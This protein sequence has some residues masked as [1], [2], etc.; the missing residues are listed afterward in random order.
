MSDDSLPV[1]V[2]APRRWPLAGRAARILGWLSIAIFGLVLLAWL[3]M[4]WA[5]LPHIERWRPLIEAKTSQA[6]GV[7]VRIGAIAV[8]SGRFGAVLELRDVALLDA[9]LQPALQLP[10]V[11]ATISMRSLLASI[12]YREPR[13]AQLLIDGAQIDV[14]RDAEGRLFVAGIDFGGAQRNG[15][16]DAADWFFKLHEFAIRGGT[17]RWTDERRGAPPLEL[18]SVDIVVRNTLKRHALRVDATPPAEWGERFTLRGKFTQP[19]LARPGNWRAWSGSLYVDLPHVDVSALAQD[20]DVPFELD[21]GAGAARA[22]IDVKDGVP[23]G[24]TADLAL[25]AVSLR[26]GEKLEPLDAQQLQGRFIGTRAPGAASAALRG[27]TLVTGDGVQWSPGDLDMRWTLAAD[28]TLTGGTLRAER[29]DL[30][31]LARTAQRIPLGAPLR[32]WL[33]L[34]DPKGSATDV[35]ASWEGPI[36]TPKRY[37]VSAALEGFSLAAGDATAGVAR[38]GLRNASLKFAAT[39]KGGQASIGIKDGAIE[40]PGVFE[41]P[42]LPFAELDGQ[43]AWRIDARPGQAPAI[44]VKLTHGR[45]ANADA[46]GE[47][48]ATWSSDAPGGESAGARGALELDATLTNADATRVA[49]YL[50]LAMPEA[51]R[52]YVQR[53]V[54]GGK[55]PSLSFR[56]RGPLADFP[57]H[58]RRTGEFR[59]AIKTEDLTFA[60]APDDADTASPWPPLTRATGEIVI[61]R[62]A[63]SFE[64]TSGQLLGLAI[65]GLKGGIADLFGHR[66]LTLQAQARGPLADMLQIVNTT[67]TGDRLDGAL[68]EMTASGDGT[69]Q[70]ALELPLQNPAGAVASGSLKLEGNDLHLR[71]DMPAL[72]AVSGQVAFDHK[73]F[74]LTAVKAKL[75]GG[76]TVFSGG[77]QADASLRIVAQGSA[78]IEALRR[79]PEWPGL[80]RLAE[81]LSG[82]ARYRLAFVRG[83]QGPHEISLTSDLVG[84]ASTLPAPLAKTADAPMPLRVQSTLAPRAPAGTIGKTP[85]GRLHV[86]LGNF[87]DAQ[88]Q[89]ETSDAGPVVLR[90]GIGV[91]EPAPTPE[92]GVA[93]QISLKSLDLDAWEAA[94]QKLLGPTSN[95]ASASSASGFLPTRIG[96]KAQDLRVGGRALT[97]VTAGISQLEGQWRATLDADQLAGYVEYGTP[98]ASAQGVASFEGGHVRARLSRLSVPRGEVEEVTHLLEKPPE[99]LP[100]LDIVVEDFELRGRHLGRLEVEAAN[101]QAPVREWVLTRLHLGLP[102]ASLKAT[103][104]WAEVGAGSRRAEFDFALDLADSGA[105]LDRTGTPGVVRGGKGSLEGTVSWLGS[106][107]A[108]DY[109]SMTGDVTVAIASGQFLQAQPGAARLLGVLSLQ[110]LARRL[111]LDFRDVFLEGFS[112]DSINGDVKIAAGVASTRKLVVSGAQAT[113]LMAGSADLARETQDL[114]IVVV[115]E[116]NAEAASLAVAVINPAIGL[117]SFL[118][119]LLLRQPMMEAG[120]REFHVTGTWADPVVEQVARQRGAAGDPVEAAPGASSVAQ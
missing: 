21:R 41:E 71:P 45:L 103:G 31:V 5:I 91:F 56:V 6:L 80:A 37:R 19:L 30:G 42:T 113:V 62:G 7:P 81:S 52:V 8:Q 33:A 70:L 98:R 28:G 2:P 83:P 4:Q 73:G 35:D 60:F 85:P 12:V 99:S 101:R 115:P 26:L 1:A 18:V 95:A 20:I 69:F 61:D 51:A 14:R 10:R 63:L 32:E 114:R 97:R 116:I 29:L 57:F 67:P 13:L 58:S 86:E 79:A 96:L 47:F 82:Q 109:A 9:Q 108:M 3:A 17:L 77:T 65:G 118:A 88:Y 84:L 119:Q 27:F 110:S 78:S 55:L 106:P 100:S 74:T 104:R 75:L 87:I 117:G 107:F 16:A 111:T 94:T 23:H 89:F 11:V 15:T 22:W 92:T 72:S 102:E 90:G 40:L 68:R 25:R 49:H 24:I 105:F 44:E 66:V 48:S 112:F 43:L 39:E 34:R 38:P 120:T 59:V 36:E 76:D 93:A 46:R 50:P 53:A 54:R 64:A